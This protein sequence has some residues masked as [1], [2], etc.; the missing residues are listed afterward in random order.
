[1]QDDNVQLKTVQAEY[2]QVE[3]DIGN[4]KAVADRCVCI[5]LYRKLTSQKLARFENERVN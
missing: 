1:M 5:L 4:V 3:K 2:N